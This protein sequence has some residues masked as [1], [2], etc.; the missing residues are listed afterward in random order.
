MKFAKTMLE[1]S[2]YLFN[3][4]FTNLLEANILGISPEALP[5]Y[6]QTIFTDQPMA[7]AAYTT[8]ME[9]KKKVDISLNGC[10]NKDI[11]VLR[12]GWR[13]KAC[14][15]IHVLGPNEHHFSMCFC[16]FQS[17]QRAIQE[18]SDGRI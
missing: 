3:V 13:A 18:W 16:V 15:K 7:I 5:A 6:V 4:H 2:F 17:R 8:E 9:E 1:K 12:Q 14:S 10:Y 11:I